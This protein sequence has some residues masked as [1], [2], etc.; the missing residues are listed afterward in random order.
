[1]SKRDPQSESVSRPEV[2][3]NGSWI[4]TVPGQGSFRILRL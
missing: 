2:S 3:S 4:Q 1:M